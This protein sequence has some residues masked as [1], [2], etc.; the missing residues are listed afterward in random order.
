MLTALRD[1]ECDRQAHAEVDRHPG[2][3]DEDRVNNRPVPAPPPMA[4]DASLPTWL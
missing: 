2:C 1:G 3:G 4:Y